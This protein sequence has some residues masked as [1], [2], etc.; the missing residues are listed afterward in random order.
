MQH[1]ETMQE[2]VE[3]VIVPY[4]REP[5]RPTCT[6]IIPTRTPLGQTVKGRVKEEPRRETCDGIDLRRCDGGYHVIVRNK[7]LCIDSG[8]RCEQSVDE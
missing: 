6:P 4:T 2:L 8:Q 7:R 5:S 1:T 3:T